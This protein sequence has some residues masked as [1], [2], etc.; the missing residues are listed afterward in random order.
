V[1]ELVPGSMYVPRPASDCGDARLLATCCQIRNLLNHKSGS[2]ASKSQAYDST[3]LNSPSGGK[4]AACDI[5]VNA[6]GAITATQSLAVSFTPTSNA[7]LSSVEI[8]VDDLSTVSLGFGFVDSYQVSIVTDNSGLPS[9]D[10]LESM[11][12]QVFPPYKATTLTSIPSRT[13]PQLVAGTKYWVVVGPDP[14]GAN[15]HGDWYATDTGA[16]GVART[17]PPTGQWV[18]DGVNPPPVRLMSRQCSKYLATSPPF[19]VSRLVQS[20]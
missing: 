16:I 6:G 1:R 4:V 12:G 18:Y 2:S 8:A 9:T 19:A 14:A 20:G 7:Q 5:T 11:G 3:S 10:V 13:H 15:V 17:L